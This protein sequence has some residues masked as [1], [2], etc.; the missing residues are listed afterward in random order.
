MNSNSSTDISAFA[1]FLRQKKTSIFACRLYCQCLWQEIWVGPDFMDS[2]PKVSWFRPPALPKKHASHSDSSLFHLG[3]RTQ[4]EC[5]KTIQKP[6]SH[7]VVKSFSLTVIIQMIDGAGKQRH[8]TPNVNV[9]LNVSSDGSELE[10]AVWLMYLFII[11]SPVP[12]D[13]MQTQ[14]SAINQSVSNTLF[15]HIAQLGEQWH[16]TLPHNSCGKCNG[17]G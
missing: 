10:S 7:F 6:A 8:T 1:T 13:S 15:I 3:Q 5:Q 11:R 14:R 17:A 9:H 16:L 4:F 12:T 2:W